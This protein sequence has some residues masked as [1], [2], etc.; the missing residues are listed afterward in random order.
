[1]KKLFSKTFSS[2]QKTIFIFI[3]FIIMVPSTILGVFSYMQYAEIITKKVGELSQYNVTQIGNN[4]E[5]IFT[6]V[7]NTSL[8]FYQN[9]FVRNYLVDENVTEET[10]LNLDRFIQNK[11]AYDRNIVAVDFLRMDK[12]KYA[13]SILN[14]GIS[15]NMKNELML[16][17][18]SSLFVIEPSE[19][20][21]YYGH[22]RFI[23]DIHHM[24]IPIGAM[25]IYIKKD[26][27]EKLLTHSMLTE[28]DRTYVIQAGKIIMST[29]QKDIGKEPETLSAKNFL[30]TRYEMNYPRWTVVS[31]MSLEKIHNEKEV[32]LR[33]IVGM[34]IVSLGVSMFAAYFVS[35]SV[36]K[37][38][39]IVSKSMENIEQEKFGIT[40]QADGYEEIAT[41]VHAFNNM[42]IKLDELVNIVYVSKAKEKDAKIK[43]LQAYINPHFLYNTLDTI[44]WMSRMENAY[45]TC[46]LIEALSKLF[47]LSV[48]NTHKTVTVEA[49]IE[50]IKSYIMIQECRNIDTIEFQLEVDERLMNY[51]TVRFVLQPIVENAIIHGLEPVGKKG[52]IKICVKQ[53]NNNLVYVIENDGL[54]IEPS[55]LEA[56]LVNK[57][58][59]SG[60]GMSNVNDRIKLCFGGYYGIFFEGKEQG[61]LRV[62]IIQPLLMGGDLL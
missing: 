14:P 34:V 36:I 22:A 35:K 46:N 1:M 29:N 31:L 59:Q 40:I 51:K 44:C 53:E 8:S 11:L 10:F 16:L 33:M 4:L 15:E 61:G 19:G 47:R 58:E 30:M 41:L 38:I 25:Q 9:D 26:N 43:E 20:S 50:H 56:Y 28:K 3:L 37:P 6:H 55:I 5:N 54:A 24:E 39:K 27:I 18:G 48:Q 62:M 17:H 42:S 21:T 57:D 2:L 52:I 7:N 60:L 23:Y 12:E 49:E 13:S 45:E 32:A